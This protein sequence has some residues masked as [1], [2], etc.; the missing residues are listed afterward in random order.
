MF[1][2]SR[3]ESQINLFSAPQSIL[4][5]RARKTYLDPQKWHN[6]FYDLVTSQIDEEI[7]SVL[8]KSGN[9]GAPTASIRIL[10]A[11][12]I[13]K[14]GF[15]CSDEQLFEKI[16]FDILVRKAVGMINLDEIPPSLDT[17]YLFNRRLC[18]YQEKTQI[19]LMEKCFGKITKGQLK[20][21]NISGKSVRM[22]SKLIGS[23]IAKYSRYEIVLRTL[24]KMLA[25]ECNRKNLNTSLLK[26]V[27]P[28]LTEK[29][30]HTVYTSDAA[31]MSEKISLLGTVVYAVLKRLKETAPEY[32]LL[33]RVFHEQFSVVGGVVT[34][35]NKKEVKCDSTQNPNDPDA[36]YR[37]KGNQ[38]VQGYSTNITETVEN[39]KPSIIT[40]VQVEGATISDCKFVEKAIE[41]TESVTGEIIENLYAD[42]A[43][44]SPENRMF[45]QGHVN[46][47]G[48]PMKIK[49]GRMQGGARFI[50]KPIGGSNNIEVI[51]TKT[52]VV[53]TGEYINT[54]ERR[55]RR[56]RIKLGDGDWRTKPF[57]Y[58][59][60][61][62]FAASQLRQ[63]IE[64]LPIEE[65]H[66]RN[67]VEASM[68]H[69][70]FHTR[71]NKTRYRGLHKHRLQAVRRCAWMNMRRL[72]I[73]ISKMTPEQYEKF[74]LDLSEA[75]LKPIRREY[76]LILPQ[77]VYFEI[78]RIVR[79]FDFW[80]SAFSLNGRH[81]LKYTTF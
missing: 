44:Q 1:R 17:Y 60:E 45:A 34:L 36:Q 51:D 72:A 38:K 61:K 69:Y 67:N 78:F 4:G 10:V 47:Q 74:I 80:K 66:K 59:E 33:H 16:E 26:R 42:G 41:K 5:D 23:N 29:G 31:T 40:S 55:G 62:D 9:M 70:S 14:E 19:D 32:E 56:W 73:Y 11:M 12:S 79:K 68:F 25:H 54:T 13:L 71:N 35:R 43:Y 53:H 39:G 24:Q 21:F 7:F 76:R 8:F 3:T 48:E 18:E 75:V 81:I 64:N 27:E 20:K 30:N 6:V 50:L 77:I 46:G 37:D 28:L 49:T 2:K 22:D 57:R 65:R 52:G 15:G 58:F 63:E